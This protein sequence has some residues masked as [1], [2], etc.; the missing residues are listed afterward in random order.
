MGIRVVERYKKERQKSAHLA[1]TKQSEPHRSVL[2][3]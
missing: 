1:T 3:E 2:F